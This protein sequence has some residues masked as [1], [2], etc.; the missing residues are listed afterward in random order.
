[1]EIKQLLLAVVQSFPKN[2]EQY[3]LAE[4]ENEHHTQHTEYK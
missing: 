4:L 1:M 2:V 3:A